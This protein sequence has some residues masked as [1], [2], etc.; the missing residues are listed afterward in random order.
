MLRLVVQV[1]GVLPP[2]CWGMV[3][4]LAEW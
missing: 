4:G 1:I 2:K 3:G